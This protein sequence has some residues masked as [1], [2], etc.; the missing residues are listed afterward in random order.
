MNTKKLIVLLV[1]IILTAGILFGCG[2]KK[3]AIEGQINS[4]SEGFKGNEA[5]DLVPILNIG[6][7]VDKGNG[8]F[9]LVSISFSGDDTEMEFIRN[10][11][12]EIVMF[13]KVKDEWMLISN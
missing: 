9:D 2:G 12:G 1:I 3:E 6:L 13:E 10:S 8:N 7:L 4:I 5:G 11:V